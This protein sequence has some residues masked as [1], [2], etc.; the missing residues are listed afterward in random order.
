ME[1]SV[2]HI[3]NLHKEHYPNRDDLFAKGP[4]GKPMYNR[5]QGCPPVYSHPEYFKI[6]MEQVRH[7][8]KTGKKNYVHGK[9]GRMISTPTRIMI[10][11]H[12]APWIDYDPRSK[13]WI[14][15]KRGIVGSQSDL[16]MQ[17]A[18]Q[19]AE[20]AKKENK[21]RRVTV[22]VQNNYAAAPSDKIKIPDNIDIISCI[23]RRATMLNA[24]NVYRKYNEKF[25]DDWYHVLN[26]DRKRF[27]LWDYVGRPQRW[28]PI[29][30]YSPNVIQRFLPQK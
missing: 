1:L 28:T 27:A 9:G 25:I 6:Y 7:F 5:K 22:M 15:L 11:P 16:L 10:G 26:H 29:P 4:D 8:D 24:Q 14:D 30:C 2:N 20:A 3:Y 17:F 21:G 19:V 23:S 13:K 18:V 12:D